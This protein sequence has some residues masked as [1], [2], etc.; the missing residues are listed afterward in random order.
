MRVQTR[1]Q[2][3]DQCEP[4][5]QLEAFQWQVGGGGETVESHGEM[6]ARP[7]ETRGRGGI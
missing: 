6:A 5:W 3:R 2:G 1:G 7:M 4:W